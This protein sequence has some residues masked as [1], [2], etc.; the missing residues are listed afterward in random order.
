[1]TAPVRYAPALFSI[2]FAFGAVSQETAPPPP[3]SVGS[4]A[5]DQRRELEV[6]TNAIPGFG[7]YTY[8]PS[9]NI[10]SIGDSQGKD[11]F[12]YDAFG[13]LKSGSLRGG[14][15]QTFTYDQYG[16]ILT[17]V[18]NGDSVVKKLGVNFYTNRID[19]LND[20]SGAPNNVVG[21][22][23]ARG[24]LISS[25]SGT[26]AYDATDAL[27]EATVDGVRR[28]HLYSAG[29][30]RVVTVR[31]IGGTVTGSDWTIRDPEGRMLRRFTETGGSVNW[32]EDYI[33]RGGQ[34]LAAEVPSSE[35]VR[36]FHVDHLG[37][38]RLIT[39]NGGVQ[40]AVHHYYPF[41]TELA[42]STADNEKVKFTGHERDASTLDYMHA[43][44]YDPSMGRF[45]SVDPGKDWDPARPQSWNM[46]AYSRNNPILRLDP[47]GRSSLVFNRESG[48]VALY[49]GEG[50]LI[51]A[52]SAANN[53]SS[54][55]K[56]SRIWPAGEYAMLDQNTPNTHANGDTLDGAY[57]TQGI[58]R[59][60]NFD[61]NGVERAGMGVH[62]GRANA[63]D[64]LGRSGF[65]HATMGCV[66]TTEEA[67]EI[68]AE[69]ALVDPLTTITIEEEAPVDDDLGVFG[70]FE[71]RTELAEP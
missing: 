64:G 19:Q 22:Y 58:F 43:R 51:G 38:P 25:P 31:S 60:S 5:T 53:A 24:N 40:L 49:S 39:G 28:Y 48:Y 69:T 44:Y 26:F 71:L 42:S 45:S 32:T 56:G 33:Y 16:N 6:A 67:M 34:L 55:S 1:M 54:N 57:G 18:T 41:G 21:T 30:E 52:W 36:H 4:V 65:E 12:V 17:V 11:T 2:L 29:G 15:G 62:A 27:K 14:E 23:D 20:A 50:M 10:T 7:N 68:I 63:T 3:V 70:A 13:R 47:D 37:T 66:R 46:Y 59:A 61:D 8:D 9:G 35:K